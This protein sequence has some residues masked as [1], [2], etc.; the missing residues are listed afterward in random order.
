MINPQGAPWP[1]S[2]CPALVQTRLSWPPVGAFPLPPRPSLRPPSSG[3]LAA[4]SARPRPQPR[5]RL[6]QPQAKR[7]CS[8]RPLLQ[9][10]LC[11]VS[12]ADSNTYGHPLP[13]NAGP[14]ASIFTFQNIGRQTASDCLSIFCQI[15][16]DLPQVCVHFS[17]SGYVCGAWPAGGPSCPAGLFY[18]LPALPLPWFLLLP[19]Q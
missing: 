9:A 7:Q 4:A 6:Q 16:P 2:S 13:L 19:S 1:E 12:S 5:S 10:N 17:L 8:Q 14:G 3:S 18:R 15:L 11:L